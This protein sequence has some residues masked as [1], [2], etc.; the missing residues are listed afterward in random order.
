MACYLF[1]LLPAYSFFLRQS[2]GI[3]MINR[4]PPLRI[5]FFFAKSVFFF[6]VCF[7]VRNGA[8]ACVCVCVCFESSSVQAS[9]SYSGNSARVG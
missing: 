7:F 3:I 8:C 9:S 2:E 1:F 6:F 5:L 4:T